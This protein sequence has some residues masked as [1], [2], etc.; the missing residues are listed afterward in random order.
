MDAKSIGKI[1][2][3]VPDSVLRINLA[4]DVLL[5]RAIDKYTTFPLFFFFSLSFFLSSL[6]FSFFFSEW[7]YLFYT[8]NN[9]GNRKRSKKNN[10]IKYKIFNYRGEESKNLFTLKW[11]KSYKEMEDSSILYLFF[12]LFIFLWYFISSN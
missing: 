4:T 9:I 8:T 6:S 11:K 2:R 7:N 1:L 5:F 3:P 12:Q 10:R